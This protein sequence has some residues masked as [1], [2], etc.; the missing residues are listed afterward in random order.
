MYADADLFKF[1]VP[2]LVEHGRGYGAHRGPKI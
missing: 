1:Q 2:Q